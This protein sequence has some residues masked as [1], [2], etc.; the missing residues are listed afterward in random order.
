ME[1][2]YQRNRSNND[3]L[4]LFVFFVQKKNISED[5]ISVNNYSFCHSG[6]Y[7]FPTFHSELIIKIKKMNNTNIA[8][9]IEEALKGLLEKYNVK[10]S[11]SFNLF[12]NRKTGNITIL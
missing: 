10:L 8:G 2:S 3:R 1:H 9:D 5:L 6:K 4:A 11:A 7:I 12:K